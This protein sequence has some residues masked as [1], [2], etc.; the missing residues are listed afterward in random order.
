[1]QLPYST[2][3]LKGV[4]KMLPMF[5]SELNQPE[6]DRPNKLINLVT[7]SDAFLS[8]NMKDQRSMEFFFHILFLEV[9]KNQ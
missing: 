2:V 1:M 9:F 6:S 8:K 5:M 3:T 7:Q 4:Q